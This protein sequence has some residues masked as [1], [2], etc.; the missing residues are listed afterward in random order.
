MFT[1]FTGLCAPIVNAQEAPP[2]PPPLSDEIGDVASEVG[3]AGDEA[4][5]SALHNAGQAVIFMGKAIVNGVE[6]VILK[7]AQGTI[8]VLAAS[9]KG[10]EMAVE[11]AKFVMLKTKEGVIWVAEQ[12]IIAGEIIVNTACQVV[13][14]I[15]D[16]IEYVVVKLAEGITFVAKKVWELAVETGE[17]IVKGVKYVIRKTKQGIIWVANKTKMLARRATLATEIRM[18]ITSGLAMGGVGQR[19]IR[20]FNRRST[21]KDPVIARL[22]KACLIASEAFN[23]AYYTSK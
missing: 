6:F 10:M 16:G 2:Q 3:A 20:Y 11:G 13:S 8:M 4:G 9:V 22:G 21:D 1:M 18:N 15:I 12:M 7:S 23:Q 17:L 5:Q 19:K 14:I